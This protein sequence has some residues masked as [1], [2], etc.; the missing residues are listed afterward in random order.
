MKNNQKRSLMNIKPLGSI[1]LLSIVFT[2]I[3]IGVS[4]LF[5]VINHWLWLSLVVLIA[6]ITLVLY[7]YYVHPFTNLKS[8][9]KNVVDAHLLSIFLAFLAYG[10]ACFPFFSFLFKDTG[11]SF[12]WIPSII[13]FSL[14]LLF[15]VCF[16]FRVVFTNT[17]HI[18]AKRAFHLIDFVENNLPNNISEAIICDEAVDTDLFDRANIVNE[19]YG[20]L[21]KRNGNNKVVLGITGCWGNGKTTY[22]NV[23]LKKLK[24]QNNDSMIICN[25]FSA[26]KYSDERAFLVG[27][28]NEIY[29][30]LDI[31]VNDATINSAIIRYVNLFL[32][33][34]RLNVG[35]ALLP[36]KTDKAIINVI[37]E[38]LVSNNKHLIFVIDNID[39]LTKEEIRFVYKAVG[40]IVDIKNITFVCL[41]DEEYVNKIIND[42]YPCNYLDKIIDLKV[43][44]NQPSSNKIYNTAYLSIRNFLAKYLPTKNIDSLDRKDKELLKLALS[45]IENVRTS[46]IIL[47]GF[48]LKV[49]DEAFYLN[50]IDY[51]A[52]NIIKETNPVLY[53][54]IIDNADIFVTAHSTY[55]N[56]NFWI[57]DRDKFKEKKKKIIKENFEDGGRFCKSKELINSLFPHSL[58]EYDSLSK[59]EE[60]KAGSGSRIYSGK[61]F[62]NYIR[63]T[64]VDFLPVYAKIKEILTKSRSKK[65]MFGTLTNILNSYVKADHA[66]LFKIIEELIDAIADDKE[67]LSWVLEYFEKN[68]YAFNDIF[69]SFSLS[70]KS[71][72]AVIID[73]LL[74]LI[75]GD[76]AIKNI[77]SFRNKAESLTLV[78]AIEYW[79]NASIKYDQIGQEF[80]DCI[81]SVCKDTVGYVLSNNINVFTKDYYRRGVLW[82]LRDKADVNAL[83]EYLTRNVNSDNVFFFLNEF[84]GS[85]TTSNPDQPYVLSIDKKNLEV[86]YSIDEI[87]ALMVGATIKSEADE[88]IRDLV[89][90]FYQEKPAPMVAEEY[91][92]NGPINLETYYEK[93]DTI[94]TE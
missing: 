59:E 74:I 40:D 20:A 65:K 21:L 27:L 53:K 37:N 72:A 13:A 52:I 41:Y 35:G 19:I 90:K 81:D 54:F 33:D 60:K 17:A 68:Y 10:I 91:Y 25:S 77:E 88:I 70:A 64:G 6:V 80:K 49:T 94:L 3:I 50:D 5:S 29:E 4:L 55:L 85:G 44:I 1:I 15:L 34:S 82:R 71:R 32:S 11:D 56:G 39:R 48:F 26:W 66:E 73:K 45:S 22:L 9:G 86:F 89:L 46:I 8:R 51:L 31:G 43:F 75:G 42:T 87:K 14:S 18:E 57:F 7:V 83:K 36:N 23:A 78:A 30:S 28:I 79:N 61:F 93:E 92:S 84:V 63:D 69:V 58:S 24:E 38:Y 2:A 16:I 47:N 67:R 12:K 62:E 76:E